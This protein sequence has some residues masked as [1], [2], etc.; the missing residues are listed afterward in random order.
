MT[1]RSTT[2]WEEWAKIVVCLCAIAVAI[3]V[4]VVATRS[5]NT[6]IAEVLIAAAIVGYLWLFLSAK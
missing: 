4:A 2:R 5:G 6:I 3:T 1:Q